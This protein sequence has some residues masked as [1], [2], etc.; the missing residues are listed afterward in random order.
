MH[1]D[2]PGPYEASVGGSENATMFTDSAS[3]SMRPYGLTKKSGLPSMVERYIAVMGQ[4]CAF[5]AH[6]EFTSRAYVRVRDSRR[7]CR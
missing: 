2:L 6:G 5:C 4:P 1:I 3:R 7:I